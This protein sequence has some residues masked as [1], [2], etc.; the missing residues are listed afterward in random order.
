MIKLPQQANSRIVVN[1]MILYSK[2]LITM[3]ISLYSTR[4]VLNAL[5]VIDYGIYG[6][7]GSVVSSFAFLNAAMT[8]ASQR[9]FASEI[10]RK[11]SIQ[12]KKIFDVTLIIFI[13]ISI[14]IFILAETV[15]LWFLYNILDIPAERMSAA[16]WVYQFAILS[17]IFTTI[18]IPYDSVIIA[19]ENMQI[20]AGISIF[21][22]VLKLLMIFLLLHIDYD[23]L[24][25]YA[26]F[27]FCSTVIVVVINKI[28]C[29]R[30]YKESLFSFTFDK[31]L[32]KTIFT[33]SSW[34]LFGAITTVFNNQGINIL[35]NVFFGPAINAA[36]AIAYQIDNAIVMFS[37]N[38]YMA[39]NPQIIKSYVSKELNR[40]FSL[41]FSGSKFAYYLLL[42][43]SIPLI[44][45]TKFILELW[46]G[47][48]KL[49]SYMIVF[50]KLVLIFS[51]V[52][53][54]E[55]PLTQ[56]VRATG[57][58]KLYQVCVGAFTLMII[59]ISYL[60]YKF[61]Y[62]EH[63]AFVVMILIYFVTTFVRLGVLKKMVNFPVID[64]ITKVLL[65]ILT[66]SIFSAILPGILFIIM[67]ES[68]LRFL[69]VSLSTILSVCCM[70][71]FWGIN[72]NEKQ[73]VISFLKIKSKR[74][75]K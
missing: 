39:L 64:Y 16:F 27:I 62:P 6:V 45:E 4:L 35:L 53:V 46:L 43:F 25:L 41:V 37:Q 68:I 42:M 65:V 14:F 56:V 32:F 15:G 52:N 54:L 31:K 22:A 48:E 33:Y 2:L 36:R 26:V 20:Y 70:V 29:N 3:F 38:F 47:E 51:L 66:V 28:L 30:K 63:T 18:K 24:K 72:K 57:N 40:T 1:T 60:L 69:I 8:S 19:R 75:E 21:D 59:P 49:N 7:V 44:L 61:G 23:K 34:N 71:F 74:I 12:L 55:S 67:Q 58:L 5:G 10:A 13:T 9:F 11:D 50:T 17:F 73:L